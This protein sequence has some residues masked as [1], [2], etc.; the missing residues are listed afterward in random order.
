MADAR[1]PNEA[2]NKKM[3]SNEEREQME[4]DRSA[5]EART[6]QQA[7]YVNRNTQKQGLG[8]TTTAAVT[9]SLVAAGLIVCALVLAVAMETPMLAWLGFAI[10]AT[11]ILCVAAIV[12]IA[13][14]R[15]RVSAPPP[16]SSLDRK[17]RLLVVADSQCSEAAVCDE[18]VARLAG[19]VAVHLVVPVRVSHLHFMADDE[20]AEHEEADQSMRI[21]VDLLQQHGIATTGSVGSDKPLESMADALASF[22]ATQVLLV[23]PPEEDSYWLERGLLEKARRLTVVPTTQVVVPARPT[24]RAQG[25]ARV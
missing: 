19:A 20:S 5:T 14:E 10:A 16:A 9:I 3:S 24:A 25:A 23:T 2:G 8:L 12:P 6:R 21:A 13:F 11:S 7:P 18:I 17:R 1:P 4:D 15:T 22:A